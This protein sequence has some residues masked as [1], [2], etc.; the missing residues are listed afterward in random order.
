MIE[1]INLSTVTNT[2]SSH[3]K[4]IMVLNRT[5]DIKY[6][7]KSVTECERS[8]ILGCLFQLYGKYADI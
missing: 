3:K 8:K 6:G 2:Y 1:S 7:F 4:C 5:D